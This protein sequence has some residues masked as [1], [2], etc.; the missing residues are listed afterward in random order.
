MVSRSLKTHCFASRDSDIAAALPPSRMS[1]SGR[2]PLRSAS[3]R[4]LLRE[5][6]IRLEERC[7]ECA[8]I[9]YELHDTL[10]Q[11]FLGASLLPHEAME[12]TD[13]DSPSRPALSHALH[14][15]RRS[16]NEGR[17][18][19]R[20]LQVTLPSASN[21][22]Q[23]FAIFLDEGT[24]AHGAKLRVYVQGK[25]RA[26]KPAIQEQLFLIGREAVGNALRHSGAAMIEIE[27][28]Y[29]CNT[30]CLLVR[31][32][33]CGICPEAVQKAQCSHWGLRGM[34]ER[35]EEIGARFGIWSGPSLGTEV[36]VTVPFEISAHA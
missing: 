35:G 2:E 19:I 16:I 26:I 17:A 25:P 7:R 34:R 1:A 12:Q 23:A 4:G 28:Q 24:P 9:G 20:G 3:R 10:L 11:G 15:V 27:V 31:D 36:R 32:N 18:A 30:V 33:G 13:A 8:R 22:E 29:R 5:D 6:V 21:L 14:L